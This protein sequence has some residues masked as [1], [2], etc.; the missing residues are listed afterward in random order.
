MR[1]GVESDG[2]LGLSP[3][4]SVAVDGACLS[5]EEINAQRAFFVVSEETANRTTLGRIKVGAKVNL[6]LPLT[7]SSRLDGHIVLGHVDCRGRIAR[8]DP[9]G[10]QKLLRVEHPRRFSRYVVEK[11]SVAVD[12]ISL[13]VSR[14]GE[15]W[16]E[17]IIIP[18]TLSR[19]TLRLKSPG[20]E[21][22]VEFDVLGKYVERLLGRNNAPSED[23]LAAIF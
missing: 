22:N 1:I 8:F 15:G 20:D 6:E 12:G 19:T 4:D 23:E 5:V 16:F 2:L 13:T 7:P 17:T 3:G 14:C 18:E 11:G 9:A 10:V 21:V